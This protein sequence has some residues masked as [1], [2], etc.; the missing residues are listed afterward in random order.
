MNPI[1]QRRL[2]QFKA[3]KRGYYSFL[4]FV[5]IFLVTLCAEFIAN[6]KPLLVS[7]KGS[8]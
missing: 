6:D 7:Y 3:N 5:G 8:Y 2:Y 4:I 1:T